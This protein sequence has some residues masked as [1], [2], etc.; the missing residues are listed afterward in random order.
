MRLQFYAA[1][2]HPHHLVFGVCVACMHLLCEGVS[3][4]RGR[5]ARWTGVPPAAG[6]Q[7]RE[8]RWY[9]AC[10]GSYSL[11]PHRPSTGFLREDHSVSQPRT[12]TLHTA[13]RRCTLFRPP[14]Q[15]VLLTQPNV[16]ITSTQPTP[17]QPLHLAA[18]RPHAPTHRLTLTL[19]CQAP[20]ITFQ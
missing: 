5:W 16:S 12:H 15:L 19:T 18:A 14:C 4:E 8:T 1:I 13:T 2:H 6:H 9:C 11:H 3:T 20:P 7:P 10:D 17:L